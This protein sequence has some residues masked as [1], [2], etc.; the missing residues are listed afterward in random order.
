MSSLVPA[1]A[2]HIVQ[3]FVRALGQ[4]TAAPQLDGQID[5]TAALVADRILGILGMN[6]LTIMQTA[7]APA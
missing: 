3:T 1:D 2:N 6:G 4:R 5:S 7:D